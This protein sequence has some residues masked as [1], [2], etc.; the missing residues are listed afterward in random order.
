MEKS[1][2]MPSFCAK[3]KLCS[4]IKVSLPGL[5]WLGLIALCALLD[6]ISKKAILTSMHYAQT[7]TLL[8]FFNLTLS[9]NPGIAFG[10]LNSNENLT[11]IL[12]VCGTLLLTLS[13]L[14]WLL[15]TPKNLK[16]QA[17][18]LAFIVGGAIGN[19]I[20]RIQHGFVVDFLDFHI[21]NW[22]WHTFNLADSFISMGAF[23]LILST[24]MYKR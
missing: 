13:L 22:H 11:K 5:P 18:G 2:F 4:R 3:Q 10:W 23:F 8:P 6:Q 9:Y 19:V 15:L 7:K 12:L 24:F 1:V 14:V 21:G 20:D 17:L 16:W